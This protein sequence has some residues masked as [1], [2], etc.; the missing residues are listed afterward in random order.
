M[1]LLLLVIFI[2]FDKHTSLE[3]FGINYSRNQFY[4]TGPR[5]F[6]LYNITDSKCTENGQIV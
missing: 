4:D 6:V 5:D 1:S 2:N 3:R